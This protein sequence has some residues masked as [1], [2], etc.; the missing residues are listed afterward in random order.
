MYLS[1]CTHFNSVPFNSLHRSVIR[2]VPVWQIDEAKENV[3]CLPQNSNTAQNYGRIQTHT[4][5]SSRLQITNRADAEGH[6]RSLIRA[7][8]PKPSPQATNVSG[9]TRCSVALTCKQTS[10]RILGAK[11]RLSV[12]ST[13]CLTQCYSII[14][15]ASSHRSLLNIL[16]FTKI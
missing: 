11:P 3:T 8:V 9:K 5:L 16:Y 10:S 6:A 2:K 14:R 15:E 7:T 12:P 1:W 4:C 13:V